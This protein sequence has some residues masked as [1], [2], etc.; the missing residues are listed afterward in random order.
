MDGGWEAPLN[1]R[2]PIRQPCSENAA[3]SLL[4]IFGAPVR[5]AL[6]EIGLPVYLLDRDGKVR[7]A[8]RATAEL[9]GDC[10]GQSY[11]TFV[12]RDHRTYVKNQF[13]RTIVGGGP[14]AFETDIVDRRGKQ[15]GVRLR[16]APLRRGE[17]IVGLVGL[18]LRSRRHGTG[19]RVDTA[20]FP[21]LTPRQSEV[22]QLLADGLD[23]REIAERLGVAAETARNHIRGLLRRLDAHSRLEAVVYARKLGLLDQARG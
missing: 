7:W 10:V 17:E 18:A 8:N 22:L 1:P 20:G 4:D 21:I 3:V 6:D 2:L 5:D 19:D 11:L 14:T 23:T 9:V 15:V 16:N 13:V 12:P